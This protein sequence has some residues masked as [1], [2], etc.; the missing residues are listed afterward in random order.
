MPRCTAAR[1]ARAKK[2]KRAK[3]VE[4]AVKAEPVGGSGCL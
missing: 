2:V 1:A 4:R 3:K